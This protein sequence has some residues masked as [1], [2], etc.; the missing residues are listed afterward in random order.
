MP[1]A[2]SG[3]SSGGSRS[4]RLPVSEWTALRARTRNSS[5]ASTAWASAPRI[6]PGFVQWAADGGCEPSERGHVAE[7]ADAVFQVG[8][9]VVRAGAGA[10]A[11][12]LA[13]RRKR[14]GERARFGLHVGDHRVDRQRQQ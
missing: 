1:A 6:N 13:I 11:A 7:P 14:V 12:S 9:E 2:T 4:V 5:A 3:C 8:S 10:L